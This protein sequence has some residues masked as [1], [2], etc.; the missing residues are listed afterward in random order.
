MIIQF[1]TNL[2]DMKLLLELQLYAF[3]LNKKIKM[4]Q[5]YNIIQVI[6]LEKFSELCKDRI[7]LIKESITDYL[8]NFNEL[9]GYQYQNL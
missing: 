2:K 9:Y 1:K 4:N 6:N 7:L 5:F 3:N 8:D